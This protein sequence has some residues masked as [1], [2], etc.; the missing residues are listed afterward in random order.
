M[1]DIQTSLEC[2]STILRDRII[3]NFEKFQ[4][5]NSSYTSKQSFR[6]CCSVTPFN[7][8]PNRSII[9]SRHCRRHFT[10]D[11]VQSISNVQISPP[12]SLSSDFSARSRDNLRGSSSQE[13]RE[14]PPDTSRHASKTLPRS[15]SVPCRRPLVALA[16]RRGSRSVRA[17][18][19]GR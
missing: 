9:H 6:S 12:S 14:N 17:E 18:F 4:S 5:S 10:R 16:I 1:E 15:P 13:N 3:Y 8:L 19:I 7:N 11:K 2:F